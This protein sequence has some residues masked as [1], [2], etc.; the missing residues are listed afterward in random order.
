MAWTCFLIEPTGIARRY[1]RRYIG[2]SH[3]SAEGNY[4]HDASVPIDECAVTVREDGVY[5]TPDLDVPHDDPR[6]PTHCACGYAFQDTDEWQVSVHRLYA[7]TDTGEEV[8]WPDAPIGAMWYA[9]W[10]PKQ[11]AGPDGKILCVQTPGGMWCID[12]PSQNGSGWTRT[13]TPPTVTAR[14]SIVA[15]SGSGGYHGWLTDGVLSDDL[16]GRTYPESEVA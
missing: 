9:P 13:G 15:R 1:L 5:D 16:E 7:R 8:A 2:D 4:Y 10:Y 3:C 14:P 6:W 12:Q 11:W